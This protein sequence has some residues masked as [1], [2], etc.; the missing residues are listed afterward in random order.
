MLEFLIA[1]AI[2]FF[3]LGLLGG[4]FRWLGITLAVLFLLLSGGLLLG[5]LLLFSPET[6][7][8]PPRSNVSDGQATGGWVL[9]LFVVAPAVILT[10]V[11]LLGMGLG[12]FVWR[13]RHRRAVTPGDDAPPPSDTPPGS[14]R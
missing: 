12:L 14:P 4:R 6:L 5:F 1:V 13:G 7:F 10:L 3:L 8:L 2:G 9:M 11:Y